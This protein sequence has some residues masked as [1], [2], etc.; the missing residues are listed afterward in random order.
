MNQCFSRKCTQF[1]DSRRRT[2]ST[3]RHAN[4]DLTDFDS[5]ELAS[6]ELKLSAAE[7]TPRQSRDY[8]SSKDGRASTLF[9]PGLN[10]LTQFH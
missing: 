6:N 9:E 10:R 1:R 7:T 8:M 4:A 5:R 2:P 3:Y